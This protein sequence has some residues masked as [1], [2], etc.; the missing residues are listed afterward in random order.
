MDKKLFENFI[1]F[2]QHAGKVAS[3]SP[4][5]LEEYTERLDT[6]LEYSRNLDREP[7]EVIDSLERALVINGN[8][9]EASE[10]LFNEAKVFLKEDKMEKYYGLLHRGI[11]VLFSA[12]FIPD[13]YSELLGML[14]DTK[15][16]RYY[17]FLYVEKAY[18]E[19][20]HLHDYEKA[21]ND[22]ILVKS[23][24][25]EMD[26]ELLPLMGY[27]DLAAFDW[28]ISLNM[29]DVLFKLAMYN[30][31]DLEFYIAM[32][33]KTLS[34]L[35]EKY[36]NNK[37]VRILIEL[38]WVQFHII[39]G[40]PQK[41]YNL[42]NEVLESYG[43]NDVFRNYKEVISFLETLYYWSIE[44]YRATIKHIKKAIHDAIN[45]GNEIMTKETIDFTIFLLQSSGKEFSI[46]S[47]EGEE[48]LNTILGILFTKDWYL[49]IDHSTKVAE[50]SLKMAKQYS[51]I[52]GIEI[53]G[54]KV[55]MA[56]LLHDIGKLYVPWYVLNKPSRLDET[57]WLCIKYHPVYGREI[58]ERI[59]LGEY[60][61]FVEE[62]HERND[63]TGYPY[64]KRNLPPLSQIIGVA[65]IFEAATTSN[66]FYKSPKSETEIIEELKSMSDIKFDHRVIEALLGALGENIEK[67]VF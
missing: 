59:G 19:H 45:S 9:V 54:E 66:R 17:P 48:V 15:N 47:K 43:K 41:A 2:V 14:K 29:V 46:Y 27:K 22:Y 20:V 8:Y 35:F 23:M 21:L 30:K 55:Y 61:R 62:H 11:S 51:K 50:L 57:E 53:E 18:A 63:G 28:R 24:F 64:G 34:E 38:F 12:V 16:T 67:A 25:D 42:L 60:A 39:E 13:I 56:G 6:F 40:K 5:V 44:D 26:V 1:N 32:A 52:T 37:Q 3:Q 36:G 65:D 58:M 4:E 33:D 10:T 49:G 31:D 7:I